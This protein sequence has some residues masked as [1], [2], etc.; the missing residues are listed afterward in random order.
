MTSTTSTFAAIRIDTDGVVADL[1]LVGA[2]ADSRLLDHLYEQIGCSLVDVIE[3]ANTISVWIDDE[4][5]LT[6]QPFN[7]LATAL[8]KVTTGTFR[9]VY[10]VVVLTGGA[11]RDGN[12]LPLSPEAAEIVHA[13]ITRITAL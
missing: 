10:G 12:T 7:L 5:L 3:L 1:D 8:T 4:A 11:D 6:A 9:P 2:G 13:A